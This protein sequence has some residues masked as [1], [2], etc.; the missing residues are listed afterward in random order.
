[1]DLLQRGKKN[2]I[3]IPNGSE[4]RSSY[5]GERSQKIY[6]NDHEKIEV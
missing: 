5:S 4:A 3:E 2:K 1:M 6:E